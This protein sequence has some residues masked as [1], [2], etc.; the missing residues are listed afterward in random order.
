MLQMSLAT[1]IA[2]RAPCAA[3][4]TLCATPTTVQDATVTRYEGT[5]DADRVLHRWTD[6]FVIPCIMCMCV[7]CCTCH[8][9]AALSC[10][11]I[12]NR[13]VKLGAPF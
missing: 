10:S 9:A 11:F 13:F 8:S 2:T 6:Q 5:R 3:L 4:V 12:G 7:E 1:A